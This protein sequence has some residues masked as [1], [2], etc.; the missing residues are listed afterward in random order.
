MTSR[1]DH[2]EKMNVQNGLFPEECEN[3]NNSLSS[4]VKMESN[5]TSG[6]SSPSEQNKTKSKSTRGDSTDALLGDDDKL[7]FDENNS[8]N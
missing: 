8:T 7:S 5:L 1:D 3:G 6:K 4:I 2:L